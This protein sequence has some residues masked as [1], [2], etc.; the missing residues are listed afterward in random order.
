LGARDNT[1]IEMIDIAPLHW[2]LATW[3]AVAAAFYTIWPGIINLWFRR[4]YPELVL[5]PEARTRVGNPSRDGRMAKFVTTYAVN[6]LVLGTSLWLGCQLQLSGIGNLKT[7]SFG[8]IDA[9]LFVPQFLLVMFA[10]DA[11]FYWVHRASHRSAVLFRIFHFE[12]HVDRYPDAWTTAYQHPLEIF[13]ASAMPMI[14][15]VLLPVHEFAWWMAIL[16][17][18]GVGLAGHSGVEITHRAPGFLAPNGVAAMIDP[19]RTGVAGWFNTVTHHDLHHQR[20]NVNF[21]LFFTLWDRL[22]GTLASDSDEVYRR[23]TKQASNSPH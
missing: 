6:V 19:K 17:I 16:T 20:Y 12:H 18:Q 1:K 2:G 5:Q 9:L 15:G 21:G 4:I 8:L 10:F 13:V 14:W 7:G 11:Q 3:I 23:A 22:M